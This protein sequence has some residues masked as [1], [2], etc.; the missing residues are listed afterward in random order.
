MFRFLFPTIM[1][2]VCATASAQQPQSRDRYADEQPSVATTTRKALIDGRL[3]EYTFASDQ[4]ISSLPKAYIYLGTG[5]VYSINGVKQGAS[6]KTLHFWMYDP[7]PP[8]RDIHH[9]SSDTN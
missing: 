3:V 5:I 9:R 1:L 2:L 7:Y 8:R 4:R 6:S